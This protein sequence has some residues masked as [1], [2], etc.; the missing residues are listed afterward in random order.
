MENYRFKSDEHKSQYM[1]SGEDE[2]ANELVVEMLIKN[3]QLNSFFLVQ[4]EDCSYSIINKNTNFTMS[5]N[6]IMWYYHFTPSEVED[7]LEKI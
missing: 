5:I 2:L 3:D 7:F 1:L 6:N 4:N